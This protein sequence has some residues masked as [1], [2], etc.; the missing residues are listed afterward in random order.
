MAIYS[1]THGMRFF[2]T[3]VALVLHVSARGGPKY[4][5]GAN[6][7]EVIKDSG[8]EQSGCRESNQKS[9]DGI[10]DCR[11]SATA[12]Q[13]GQLFKTPV[14]LQHTAQQRRQMPDDL[15]N[16]LCMAPRHKLAFRGF[17]LR[18]QSQM[19]DTTDLTGQIRI[20]NRSPHC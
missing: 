6:T 7:T 19:I 12:S 18:H 4:P 2:L 10:H 9:A 14:M 1:V 15:V 11:T 20:S 5:L 3:P 8:R 17:E 13:H 16:S